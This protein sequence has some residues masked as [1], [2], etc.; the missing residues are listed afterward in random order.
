MVQGEVGC[1]PGL[2]WAPHA[3]PAGVAGHLCE[4]LSCA[5]WLGLVQR[6]WV[7]R[8]VLKRTSAFEAWMVAAAVCSVEEPRAGSLKHQLQAA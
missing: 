3:V 1:P 5:A 6:L 7:S 8:I 2:V 4:L